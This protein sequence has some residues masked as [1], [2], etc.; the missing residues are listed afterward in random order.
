[1]ILTL[2]FVKLLILKRSKIYTCE[3]II[4]YIININLFLYNWYLNIVWEG[5][6][7]ES[8]ETG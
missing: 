4:I 3:P 5:K 1:M 8:C 2:L 6:S 7:L